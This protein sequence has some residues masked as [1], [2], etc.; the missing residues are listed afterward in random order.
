M[1]MK[2]STKGFP[3]A[4]A[5]LKG[6]ANAPKLQQFQRTLLNAAQVI[7]TEVKS[8]VHS[9]TG[10]TVSAIVVVPGKGS[11]PSAI[12]K[13]DKRLAAAVSR[14]KRFP[15]PYAVEAGHGGPHPAAAHPFFAKAVQAKRAEARRIIKVGVED[16][17]DPY[18]GSSGVGGQFS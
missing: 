7:A 5:K 6:M 3:E 12:I 1:A 8:N 17:L 11:S 13:V 16:V 18:I 9:I 2:I 14:G 4:V 10:R 15:Y